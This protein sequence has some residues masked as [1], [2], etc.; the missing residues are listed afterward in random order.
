MRGLRL[1][2]RKQPCSALAP[3]ASGSPPLPALS[4]GSIYYGSPAALLVRVGFCFHICALN[5]SLCT[6]ACSAALVR[7]VQCRRA[8]SRL[9]A[10]AAR[11]ATA[12]VDSGC[13][14]IRPG[15]GLEDQ[16]THSN[17]P[18]APS[19]AGCGSMWR[20]TVVATAAFVAAAVLLLR[21]ESW[22]GRYTDS[23]SA[24]PLGMQNHGAAVRGGVQLG[25]V[26]SRPL[27]TLM[28]G[29]SQICLPQAS[30]ARTWSANR[31]GGLLYMRRT[32]TTCNC[33][34]QQAPSR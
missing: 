29:P 16:G 10:K 4:A 15:K 27:V 6:T 34:S 2:L 3:R 26:L 20:R 22:D 28:R 12:C 32:P 9:Q 24:A 33:G 30:V 19:S 17:Y 8:G 1:E 7:D 13:L 18:A 23:G 21:Q 11:T 5:L 31:R 14:R 25:K